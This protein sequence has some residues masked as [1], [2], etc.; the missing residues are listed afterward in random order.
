MLESKTVTIDTH[1]A[2]ERAREELSLHI[3]R[4]A[5]AT[6]HLNLLNYSDPPDAKKMM[7]EARR[8]C[9]AAKSIEIRAWKLQ[10]LDGE[11]PA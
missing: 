3:E 7:D 4:A 8:L 1:A 6:H 10:I 9:D 5:Q 11:F 2:R